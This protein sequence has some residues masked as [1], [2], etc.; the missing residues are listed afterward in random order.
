MK[1]MSAG[2]WALRVAMLS[3]IRFRRS[4]TSLVKGLTDTVA[5]LGFRHSVVSSQ[6]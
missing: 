3:E 4:A 2:V 5:R 6:T 1:P